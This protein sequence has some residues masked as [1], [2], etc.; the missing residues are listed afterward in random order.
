MPT[1]LPN[2]VRIYNMSPHPLSFEDEESGSVTIAPSDG[3]INAIIKTELVKDCGSYSLS[4]NTF[5]ATREGSYIIHGIRKED[6]AAV[7]VGSIV[8]AQA[9]VGQ[10]VAPVPISGNRRDKSS[11]RTV[12]SNRFTTF[13]RSNNNG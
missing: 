8:A 5:H 9:Y 10:V 3:V 7:I 4:Y 1:T 12:R 6:K 2:G 11:N 13:K